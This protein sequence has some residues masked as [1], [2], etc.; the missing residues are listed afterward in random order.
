MGFQ[1]NRKPFQK[2]CRNLPIGFQYFREFNRKSIKHLKKKTVQSL[3]FCAREMSL[4]NNKRSY[5]AVKE[6]NALL[7]VY[8]TDLVKTIQRRH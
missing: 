1:E 8:I 4:I 5:M 6:G 2:H 3:H 7:S